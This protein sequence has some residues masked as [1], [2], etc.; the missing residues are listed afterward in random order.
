MKQTL[1]LCA[2]QLASAFAVAVPPARAAEPPSGGGVSSWSD[3]IEQLRVLPDRLLAQLPPDLQK[4][5]QV[6][7]EV[8]RL[9][10]ESLAGSSLDA[11]SGDGDHPAFLANQNLTL[12]LPMPNADTVYRVSR[13]TPGGSYRLRGQRGS[14]RMAHLSQIGSGGGG[15]RSALDLGAL[16]ADAQG[17]YDL[18]LSPTRPSGYTGDWWELQPSTNRLLLRLVSSDWNREQDP[19]ISIERI[20]RPPQ[21]ARPSAADL[22]QR[23]RDLPKAVALL[24]MMFV[25]HTSKL[26]EEGYLNRLKLVDLSQAGGVGGQAYYEGA[27]ELADDEALLIEAR[28]PAKCPYYSIILGNDLLETTDWSNNLSSLNDS[29]ARV[30]RDGVLRVVI[31]ARDPGAANWLDT[32]G[33]RRGIVQGRWTGCPTP[34]ELSARKIAL[35]DLPGILPP[36]AAK[37]APSEREAVIRERRFRVQQRPLW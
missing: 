31:S 16:H 25:G 15:A 17:M 5:P 20:D 27:Y 37:V 28:T 33:Y 13:V 2:L 12:D 22:E 30:D 1:L 19:T 18:I 4:D 11:I 10:L 21:R 8:G 14:L 34:P 23:L 24:P 29:Q 3:F 26:R 7:Q 32:A 6:Q 36:G 9:V 35:K